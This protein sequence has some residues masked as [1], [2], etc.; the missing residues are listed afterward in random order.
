MKDDSVDFGR[1]RIE[2]V[3]SAIVWYREAGFSCMLWR[4]T[5]SE[6][7]PAR[8]FHRTR[9]EETRPYA[10][11]GSTASNVDRG[12]TEKNRATRG[13]PDGLVAV[14]DDRVFHGDVVGR[15]RISFMR[16]TISRPNSSAATSPLIAMT[17]P[18][19]TTVP[20][21]GSTMLKT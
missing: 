2:R 19:S 5:K 13:D 17:L 12:W 6:L 16:R 15:A 18:L 21:R 10:K 9:A 4:K 14:A 8:T 11:K 3:R 1:V 20:E 7:P